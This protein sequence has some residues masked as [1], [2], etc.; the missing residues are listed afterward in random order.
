MHYS[1]LIKMGNNADQKILAYCRG[2]DQKK[3]IEGAFPQ[4]CY[5]A[6]Y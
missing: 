2:N 1:D 3:K 6:S 4:G 5:A